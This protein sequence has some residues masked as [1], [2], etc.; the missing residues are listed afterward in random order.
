MK[1][2]NL[3]LLFIVFFLSSGFSQPRDSWQQPDKIMDILGIQAGMTIGEVGAGDGYFTFK[4][5][6]R[7]GDSGKIYAND[8]AEN[9]LASIRNHCTHNEI[10]NIETIVGGITDPKFPDDSLDI[11]IMVY[12]FHD[13]DKPVEFLKNS[14]KYLLPGIRLVIVDR[15]PDKYGGDYDHFMTQKQVIRKVEEANFT[16][17]KIET[18]LSRD[19]IYI[20]KPN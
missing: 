20:C 12:V 5:S 4:L 1:H 9:D 3:I 14:R 8:I 13:L 18:F 2:Q 11:I 7:V 17:E 16:V 15:D 19:N 6:K 10:S